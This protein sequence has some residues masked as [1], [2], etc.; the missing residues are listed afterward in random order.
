MNEITLSTEKYE[1]LL[2]HA[3]I[4]FSVRKLF[5]KKRDR[6]DALYF[7]DIMLICEM[8]GWGEFE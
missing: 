5:E 6:R 2:Y 7:T 3:N 8:F 1:E 4:G